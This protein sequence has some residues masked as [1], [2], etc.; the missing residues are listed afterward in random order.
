MCCLPSSFAQVVGWTGVFAGGMGAAPIP[1]TQKKYIG[2]LDCG[3]IAAMVLERSVSA[4]K[5]SGIV[6]TVASAVSSDRAHQ[7]DAAMNYS[8][9]DPF[10]A[11]PSSRNMD[12][13]IVGACISCCSRSCGRSHLGRVYIPSSSRYALSTRS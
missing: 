9:N 2:W 13:V 5:D 4:K 12:K 3:D 11:V 8:R 10:W 7:A 1:M 6:S